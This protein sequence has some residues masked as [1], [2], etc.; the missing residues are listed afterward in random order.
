MIVTE[1][2]RLLFF[3]LQIQPTKTG[4]FGNLLSLCYSKKANERVGHEKHR[5]LAL[6][7][8][9]HRFVYFSRSDCFRSPQT[10]AQD[11]T[12]VATDVTSQKG[13]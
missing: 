3:M 1:G 12:S 2:T 7:I 9:S 4:L 11:T 13:R 10:Q 8:H 6:G 5:L